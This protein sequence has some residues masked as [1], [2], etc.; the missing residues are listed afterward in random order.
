MKDQ[1][2]VRKVL[3][4]AIC[5]SL[6]ACLQV[7]QEVFIYWRPY[8]F[9]EIWR[10][11]TAHWVHVGWIHYALNMIAF[12]CLP[13]IFPHVKNRYLIGL[14]LLLPP[15]V[16]LSFYFCIPEIE[17]YAG[18]SGILHGLYGATAIY[19][20]KFKS[21]R[22]FAM[23]VIALALLKVFWENFIGSL[24]TS[25]LIGSPVL[26]EAH[27]IGLVWGVVLALVLMCYER[28]IQ[29]SNEQITD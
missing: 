22:K 4:I 11:W 21:E 16:S 26:I 24:E 23:L 17:A 19:F 2:L 28:I 12:A 20:L 15:L 7:F 5:M 13:F 29:K 9:E 18:L 10:W 6:S 8:F 1:V 3:F 27:W 14:I 25:Q